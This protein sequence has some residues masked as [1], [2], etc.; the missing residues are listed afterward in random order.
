MDQYAD[1]DPHREMAERWPI[2]P[3]ATP[4]HQKQFSGLANP[5]VPSWNQSESGVMPTVMSTNCSPAESPYP[6][7]LHN[8]RI[9]GASDA[10]HQDIG[11]RNRSAGVV[12]LDD[13]IGEIFDGLDGLR[14][15]GNT[16][17]IFTSDNG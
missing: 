8:P 15:T 5:H 2:S 17:V 9:L 10:T 11:W 6:C 1:D 7:A 13:M 12:D 4:R 16:F 3:C 14:V